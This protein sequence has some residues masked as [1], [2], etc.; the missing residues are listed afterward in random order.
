MTHL[1]PA[2]LIQGVDLSTP[3]AATA[4]LKDSMVQQTFHAALGLI[5]LG[6][7]R[8]PGGYG[9]VVNPNNP[10]IYIYMHIYICIIYA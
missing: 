1:V 6:G 7:D 9:R 2:L 4:T 8:A 10:S 3:A 5:V